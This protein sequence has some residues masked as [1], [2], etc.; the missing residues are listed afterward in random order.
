MGLGWGCGWGWLV[1]GWEVVWI[2]VHPFIHT[3]H[4]HAQTIYLYIQHTPALR[5][6]TA[7]GHRGEAA[8]HVVDEDGGVAPQLLQAD[9]NLFYCVCVF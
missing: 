9:R 2:M 3:T 4:E 1:G 5:G 7:A 8:V 6:V